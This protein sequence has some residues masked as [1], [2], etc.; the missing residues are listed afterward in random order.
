[1]GKGR[2]VLEKS[3][4]KFSLQKE[5]VNLLSLD[6]SNL[7]DMLVC[8]DAAWRSMVFEEA[9]RPYPLIERRA[10]NQLSRAVGEEGTGKV[11]FLF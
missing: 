11:S 3:Q 7:E 10:R 4:E 5:M 6:L 1:L 8:F 9:K 2:I